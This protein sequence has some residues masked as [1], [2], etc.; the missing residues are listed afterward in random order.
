[1]NNLNLI[2]KRLRIFV[3]NTRKMRTKTLAKSLSEKNIRSLL[4]WRKNITSQEENS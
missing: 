3:Q 4:N 1:M 2:I